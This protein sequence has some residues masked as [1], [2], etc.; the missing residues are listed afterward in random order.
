MCGRVASVFPVDVALA[1]TPRGSTTL[2]Q[3]PG[4]HSRPRRVG[5][6]PPAASI[7]SSLSN[8]TPLPPCC[9]VRPNLSDEPDRHCHS[10]VQPRFESSCLDKGQTSRHTRA[11]APTILPSAFPTAWSKRQQSRAE[12]LHRNSTTGTLTNRFGPIRTPSTTA[13]S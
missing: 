4:L 7:I 3:P 5:G 13:Q 10:A 11:A 6:R 1:R 2:P 12:F 8:G 9:Q